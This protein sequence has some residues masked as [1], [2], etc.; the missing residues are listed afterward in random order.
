[1]QACAQRGSVEIPLRLDQ[2]AKSRKADS[3]R[4]TASSLRAKGQPESSAL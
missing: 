1:L 2:M 4:K 3:W